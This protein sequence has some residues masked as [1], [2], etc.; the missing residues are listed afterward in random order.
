MDIKQ[1]LKSAGI[2]ITAQREAV[3]SLVKESSVPLSIKQITETLEAGTMDLSTLYRILDLFE[4][5]DLI[6][7]TNLVEP[8]QAVYGY[9]HKLH[10]HLLICTGCDKIS[11]ISG[12]PLHEYEHQ[13]ARERNYIIENHQL[14]L[15]GL[16]PACQKEFKHESTQ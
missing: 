6:T 5:R 8:L 10:R 14:E 11:V 1:E 13:V 3:L 12:C 2:R 7:K 16:C 4:S 15:Y 9:K